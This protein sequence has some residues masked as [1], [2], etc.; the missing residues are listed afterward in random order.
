[1]ASISGICP[2]L[3]PYSLGRSIKKLF[4]TREIGIS[5][6]STLSASSRMVPAAA[7]W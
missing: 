2:T 4:G 3:P 1:M 7:N 5:A 6:L